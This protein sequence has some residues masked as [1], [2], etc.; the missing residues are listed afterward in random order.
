[1][2]SDEPGTVVKVPFPY[3][4]R[5][6]TQYRP[7][8]VLAEVADHS[9]PP[10]LWVAMITSAANRRWQGDIEIVDSSGAGLPV[11]SV[12]RPSKIATIASRQASPIGVLPSHV[13]DEVR[14]CVVGRLD[15]AV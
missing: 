1:M 15:P 11:T 6:T 7:A 9:G 14:S 2:Q 4:N 10:L 8:L 12:V 5:P 3:S 13:F